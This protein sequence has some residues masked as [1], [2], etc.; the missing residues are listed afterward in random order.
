[1]LITANK[2]HS[3]LLS[4]TNPNGINPINPPTATFASLFWLCIK[5]PIKTI[6][7]P[8]KITKIPIEVKSMFTSGI[9][10]KIRIKGLNISILKYIC[11]VIL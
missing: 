8:M 4:L 1:M 10:L 9:R 5:V 7:K 2:T 11:F 6:I 3:I